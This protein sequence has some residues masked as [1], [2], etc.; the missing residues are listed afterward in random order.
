MIKLF[1]PPLGK[2]AKVLL[3]WEG[4]GGKLKYHFDGLGAI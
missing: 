1:C 4:G 2:W 3:N